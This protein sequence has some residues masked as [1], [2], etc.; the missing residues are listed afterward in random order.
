MRNDFG[1]EN[2][3]FAISRRLIQALF[4][5][6]LEKLMTKISKNILLISGSGR[7]VGKTTYMQEVIRQNAL[8]KLTAIKITPHF[9]EPTSGLIPI[10]VNENFCIF[11]ETN[12]DSEKDSSLFL[13]AGAER[14]FYIQTSDVFLGEAFNLVYGL[15]S[16]NQPVIVESAALRKFIVPGFY[17]FIEKKSEEMKQSAKEMQ[18][19]ADVTIFSDGEHFSLNP[20]SVVFNQSWKIQN[21]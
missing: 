14:V 3:D 15:L 10:S 9:H 19:L 21:T 7:N 16:T 1:K 17:L 12:E 5:K 13:Q 18:K 2:I 4:W 6:I 20:E 11:Q 8:Q